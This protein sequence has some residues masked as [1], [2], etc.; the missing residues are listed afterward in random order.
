MSRSRR[1]NFKHLHYFATIA[2]LGSVSA[3]A[4]AL[5]VAPQTVSAQLLE[6]ERSIGQPLFERVGRRLVLTAAGDTALDY[7]NAIFALGDELGAV[8]RGELRPRNLSL[9]VGVTDSVSKLMTMR[10]LEP[11]LERHGT[12]LALD[13][14]EGGYAELLGLVAAGEIDLVLA[15]APMPPG[16]SRALQSHVLAESGTSFLAARPLATRLARSFPSSLDD[17]PYLAGTAHG[18]LLAQ[19]IEA[20]FARI[21]VRPAV[22]GRIEDSALLK[23]FGQ[24]GLGVIAVPTMVE[25]EATRHYRLGLVG[26]TRDVQQSV[27]LVRARRRRVHPLVAEIEAGRAPVR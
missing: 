12:A 18:A 13:C 21:G 19:V 8:L 2:R 23:S 27:Y 22:V 5:H 24:R 26:R 16:M 7:S 9:R 6:L 15:D 17:A 11:V 4:G 1:L 14:R 10:I 20:W 3:A 25:A